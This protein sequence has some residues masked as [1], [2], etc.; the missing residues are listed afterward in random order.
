MAQRT[1]KVCET[2]PILVNR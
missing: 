1:P 2:V